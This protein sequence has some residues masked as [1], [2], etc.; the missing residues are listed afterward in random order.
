MIKCIVIDDEPLARTL[1][2]SHIIEVPFLKLLGSFKN[3]ILAADFLNKNEVDLIF[4]DIQ[5]PKLTGIDFL[6]TLAHPPK[7]IFTTAY[8]EYA[9]EGFELQVLDYLLKPITFDRFFK[10]VNRLNTSNDLNQVAHKKTTTHLDYIFIS[11]HKKQIKIILKDVLYIESLRDYLKIHLK[12]K[13]HVIKE[14]ISNFGKTLPDHQFL[15]IHRSYIV[16]IEQ[17]T[18]FTQ[19]DIEIGAIEIPIGGKYKA[20]ALS[21]LKQMH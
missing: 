14:S 21:L 8:R 2:E 17:I 3:A 18:A 10:A 7:V 16:N 19:Q 5:M 6:K 12:N 9:I 1:I 11:V 15:R 20:Y 4:L 13:T